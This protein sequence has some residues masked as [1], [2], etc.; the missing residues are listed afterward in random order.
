MIDTDLDK[1]VNLSVFSDHSYLKSFELCSIQ[2]N[3]GKKSPNRD[4]KNF[5]LQSLVQNSPGASQQGWVPKPCQ[6]HTGIW[7]GKLLIMIAVPWSTAIIYH[8]DTLKWIA[9]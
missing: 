4:C 5:K 8:I 1:S 2:N 3:V 6:A 9:N 7:T